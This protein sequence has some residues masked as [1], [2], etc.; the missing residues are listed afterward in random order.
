MA[1]L[2]PT[3]EETCA[4]LSSAAKKSKIIRA[5]VAGRSV[6]GR[7]LWLATV[8]DFGVPN[9]RKQVVLLTCGTHGSEESGR[10]LG[11]AVLDW[12]QTPAA[13]R[14]L[15]RQRILLFT[16]VNPDG[17]R[18]DTYHNAADVNLFHAYRESGQCAAPEAQ[19]VWDVAMRE[20]PEAYVDC[21]GLAGGSM[22]ELV[23]PNIGR[24]CSSDNVIWQTIT[25]D[26]T[27]A[28][29]RAGLPQQLSHPIEC[30]TPEGTTTLQRL[31]WQRFATLGWTLEMNEGYLTTAETQR[32]GLSR[33][34]ALFD[35]GN[36][37]S[38]GLPFDGYPI[39]LGGGSMG[40]VIPH[41]RTPGER[42]ANRAE[43]FPFLVHVPQFGRR[44]DKDGV[45]SVTLEI[46]K[47]DMRVPSAF[48]LMAR[49]Y[50][51]CKVR[52]VSFAGKPL[53]LGG[54]PTGYAIDR[55]GCG[56]LV[57]TSIGYRLKPGNYEL[58]VEYRERKR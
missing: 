7:E 5:K 40:G 52:K 45:C 41:G 27:C 48:G 1:K 8:T 34:L 44:P 19:A 17:A 39:Y 11:M 43:V 58:R 9:D 49:L 42:R 14:T 20:K 4:H 23:L 16:C 46:E 24:L 37:R 3:Y 15:R 18:R 12:A 2:H 6:E 55:S 21:H 33:L 47:C 13:R 56:P 30:W 31:L 57:V 35:Y 26:M 50:P 28:A 38:F 25:N 54:F 22:H 32:S 53:K 10:A 51:W 29:E 36:R